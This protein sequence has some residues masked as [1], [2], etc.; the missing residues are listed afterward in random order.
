MRVL[1]YIYN[2]ATAPAHVE[3][4]L[5]DLADRPESVEHIDVAAFEDRESGIR[6][7]ML[8]LRNAVRI[9][10]NPDEIYDD[11]GAPDF[12]VGALITEAPTG[13]RTLHVGAD[14]LEA[15]AEQDAE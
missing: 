5:E 14:A 1:T 10:D 7:A 11:S 6:E 2:S 8:E 12:S 9:G 4:V 3:S 13:R 15:L